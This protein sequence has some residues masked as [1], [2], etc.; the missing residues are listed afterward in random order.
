MKLEQARIILTGASGGIGQSLA[1]EL[2]KHHARLGVVGRHREALETLAN[3]LRD[4]GNEVEVIEADITRTEGS[5]LVL[6]RMQTRFG[7]VDVLINNAGISD[8]TEFATQDPEMME[9]IFMTNVLAPMRLSAVVLPDMLERGR[10]HIVNVGSIFGSIAFAYFVS[11][12]ASK[13]AL[14]GFSEALRRELAGS[15]VEVTYVAPRAVKT[16]LNTPK[17]CRMAAQT[18]M[19]MDE[20]GWVA[21][22]IVS[23]IINNRKDVY[24]GFPEALFVRINALFPRLVDGA[25]R[26]QGVIMRD[27]AR[28]T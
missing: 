27:Y 20:P 28:E 12:S 24:L 6:A 23:A 3:E 17:I 15:G 10:G 2:S 14:R 13:S 8:F 4:Q 9:R 16:P 11:Y 19:H 7:G 22:R 18:K 26:K 25:L 5:R 21:Q 1:R